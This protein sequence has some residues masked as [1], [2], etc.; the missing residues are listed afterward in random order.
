MK[1]LSHLDEGEVE[2][3]KVIPPQGYIQYETMSVDRIVRLRGMSVLCRRSTYTQGTII[4]SVVV[5]KTT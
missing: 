2:S 4:Y 3:R 1:R 5:Q